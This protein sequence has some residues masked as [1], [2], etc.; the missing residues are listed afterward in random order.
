MR[1]LPLLFY[2]SLIALSHNPLLTSIQTLP[3]P[4]SPPLIGTFPYKVFLLSLSSDTL[5]LL[6]KYDLTE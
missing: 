3:C 6:A 1:P 4:Q 5:F 2:H